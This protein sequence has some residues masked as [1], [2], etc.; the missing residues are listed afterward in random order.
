MQ[1]ARVWLGDLEQK[2]SLNT[3][4]VPEPSSVVLLGLGG[5]GFAIVRY[6]RRTA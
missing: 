1:T 4:Y 5:L 6:R 3:A 2:Y